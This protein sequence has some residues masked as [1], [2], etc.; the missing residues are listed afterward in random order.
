MKKD[1]DI[2]K[3]ALS[4]IMSN[5]EVWH[6]YVASVQE[7]KGLDLDFPEANYDGPVG[8]AHIATAAIRNTAVQSVP[9]LLED[10]ANQRLVID[11]AFKEASKTES[12]K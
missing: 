10:F 8:R 1:D 5:A 6:K 2:V 9:E 7:S 4:A 11:A 12:K 3:R